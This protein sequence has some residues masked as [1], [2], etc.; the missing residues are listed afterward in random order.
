VLWCHSLSGDVHSEVMSLEVG[1]D[2][3]L[4]EVWAH[5]HRGAGG[6]G[7]AGVWVQGVS[8]TWVFMRHKLSCALLKALGP[9]CYA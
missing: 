8:M 9:P 2:S 1:G 6:G 4:L 7:G 3:A 5:K